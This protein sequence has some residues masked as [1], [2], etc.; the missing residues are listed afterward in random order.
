MFSGSKPTFSFSFPRNAIGL[1]TWDA[2]LAAVGR[3][4]PGQKAAVSGICAA[5]SWHRIGMGRRSSFRV[6]LGG[7]SLMLGPVGRFRATYQIEA[8]ASKPRTKVAH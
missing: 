2:I 6:D 8:N 1:S 7:Q 4:Q 5:Q 3:P